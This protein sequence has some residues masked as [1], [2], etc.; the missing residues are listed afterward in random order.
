ME[1]ILGGGRIMSADD[2]DQPLLDESVRCPG[3]DTSRLWM[4][5]DAPPEDV[6]AVATCPECRTHILG[7]DSISDEQIHEWNQFM[8]NIQWKNYR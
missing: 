4:Y 8:T 7:F 6:D 5:F 2:T 1:R 3:C